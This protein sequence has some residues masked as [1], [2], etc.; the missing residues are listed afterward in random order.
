M[1]PLFRLFQSF[2]ANNPF[3]I[4]NSYL[5]KSVCLVSNRIRHRE[6]L[7]ESPPIRRSI[8]QTFCH[9]KCKRR[10]ML[11]NHFYN[12]IPTFWDMWT[13]DRSKLLYTVLAKVLVYVAAAKVMCLNVHANH[14]GLIKSSFWAWFFRFAENSRLMVLFVGYHPGPVAPPSAD[15]ASLKHLDLPKYLMCLS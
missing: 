3:Y 14:F 5:R 2:E 8:L 11:T 7:I 13:D 15:G 4:T 1:W 12:Y 6:F 9:S 10:L